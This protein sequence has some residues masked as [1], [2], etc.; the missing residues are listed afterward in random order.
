VS[1]SLARRSSSLSV[2]LAL[3]TTLP[4]LTACDVGPELRDAPAAFDSALTEGG[5]I[6]DDTS[7]TF[8]A[9]AIDG[10]RDAGPATCES[11]CD[12]RSSGD[13]CIDEMRCVLSAEE[14]ACS[15]AFGPAEA[16]EACTALDA[17]APGLACFRAARTTGGVCGLVCCPGDGTRCPGSARCGGDGM[18]VD[19]TTTAWGRC[20][21]PRPCSVLSPELTCEA[22]EGCYVIDGVGGTECR[23][24]GTGEAGD[25][26]TVPEDCA[27]GLFC[28]G[29][30]ERTCLRICSLTMTRAC[31]S[32]ERCV[33]Q[34]YS[35]DGTGIC[36]ARAGARP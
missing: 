26:C 4:C 2:L 34:T 35:P 24:A 18:L 9:A 5:I 28:G 36:I 11:V 1:R 30:S 27:G 7:A 20:V 33:A 29:L 15:V 32:D 21:P 14:P 8:D 25:S 3:V 22:R 19:G 6:R 16:G 10:G 17:C 12:P 23:L 13:G 31:T